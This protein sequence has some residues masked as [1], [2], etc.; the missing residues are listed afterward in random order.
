V[1]FKTTPFG[2]SG[3]PPATRLSARRYRDR[4]MA[5]FLARSRTVTGPD[6]RTWTVKRVLLPRPPRFEGWKRTEKG[7]ETPRPDWAVPDEPRG[8]DELGDWGQGVSAA[9][10][11]G[12][13]LGEGP[14]AVLAG[15][16]VVVLIGLA[17]FLIFPVALFLVDV[18][19]FVLIAVGGIAVRLLFRRPWKIQARTEDPVTESHSWG[20]V[21]MRA[22]ADAVDAVARVIAQGTRPDDID[23]AR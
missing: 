16:L 14:A 1:V 21:G 6:G 11:V 12:N 17:W 8:R 3:I 5:G 18:V 19:I 23:L 10:D 9:M 15:I 20:V 4:R 13:V 2:R 7:P 22:S